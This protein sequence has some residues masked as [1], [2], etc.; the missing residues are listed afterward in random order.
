MILLDRMEAVQMDLEELRTQ[1]VAPI[2]VADALPLE[3][4]IENINKA[5][6]RLKRGKLSTWRDDD[7]D[8]SPTLPEPSSTPIAP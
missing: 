1:V 6:K 3:M 4:H 5:I 8:E 7:P 2:I